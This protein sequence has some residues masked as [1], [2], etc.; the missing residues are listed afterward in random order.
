[1]KNLNLATLSLTAA[2]AA[3][4]AVADPLPVPRGRNIEPAASAC[5]IGPFEQTGKAGQYNPVCT[6]LTD[7]EKCLALVKRHMSTTDGTL[8]S[9]RFDA[10]RVAYCLDEFRRGLLGQ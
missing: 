10:D 3:T 5:G 1:M 6:Q 8:R 2:L 7:A 9:G 4:Q